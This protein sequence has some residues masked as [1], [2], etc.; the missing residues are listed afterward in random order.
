MNKAA[1]QKQAAY[2]RG[3][4]AEKAAAAYLEEKGFEIIEQ[5][6]KTRHGE[7]DILA[8]D[9]GTV[10]AVEVKMRRDLTS[11][12]EAVTPVSQRRIQNALLSYLAQH[13]MDLN[14]AM[15]FDVIAVTPPL[16]IHHLD[17]AW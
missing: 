16:C 6:Y 12:L 17:N 3:L 10:V 2:E 5:R 11:A 14:T 15:R 8:R 9:G 1:P 4:S 13:D 7:I